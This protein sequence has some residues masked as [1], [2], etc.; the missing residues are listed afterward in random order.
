MSDGFQNYQALEP[1]HDASVNVRA[2]FITRTYIHLFGA[3]LA[4]AGIEYA[5]FSSGVA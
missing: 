2:R 4:F 1:V 5:L 3:I